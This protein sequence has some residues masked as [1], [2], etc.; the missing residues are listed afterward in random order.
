AGDLIVKNGWMEA[1]R[2]AAR[3]DAD[4]AFAERLARD[5]GISHTKL[6]AEELAAAE[7]H[8]SHDFVDGLKWNDPWSVLD[9]HALTLA[10][11]RLFESL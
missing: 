8:L 9:P 7:P 10:Y 11:V 2:T 1:Y 4:F 5:H 6:D 3:R